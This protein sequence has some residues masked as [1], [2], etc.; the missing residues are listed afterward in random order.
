MSGCN[1][2]GTFVLS[3]PPRLVNILV[4]RNFENLTLLA[5]TSLTETLN[6]ALGDEN[7]SP[8]PPRLASR[9]IP[10]TADVSSSPS[11]A[12]TNPVNTSRA[13]TSLYYVKRGSRAKHGPS[14]H[15]VQSSSFA[16]L[17]LLPNATY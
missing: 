8:L 2:S 5:S 10:S 11:L 13:S 14:V 17:Y 12:W 6:E 1:G 16:G 15:V 4:T 7:S 9:V 3:S